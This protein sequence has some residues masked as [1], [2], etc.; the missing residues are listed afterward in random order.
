MK[1]SSCKAK[2]RR[3]QQLVAQRLLEEIYIPA[4]LEED[5]CKSVSM[6]VSGNDIVLSPAAKKVLNLSVECKNVESLNHTT[7]FWNHYNKH[8]DNSLKL[9]ISQ[10]NRTKPVV[11][12]QLE[13][14]LVL[15][16]K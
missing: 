5:D 7:T 2:G 13:D 16:K 10:R 8:Q 9:L 4:G 3:L 15:L 12:L 1:T 6:G 11:T 14:F